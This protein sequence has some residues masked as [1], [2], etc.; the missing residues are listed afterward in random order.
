LSVTRYRLFVVS[1]A[2]GHGRVQFGQTGDG[3]F[4]NFRIKADNR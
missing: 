4:G 3:S 1:A 2:A